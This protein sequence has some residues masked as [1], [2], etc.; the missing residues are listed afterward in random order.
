MSLAGAALAASAFCTF[1][2]NVTGIQALTNT[3]YYENEEDYVTRVRLYIGHSLRN[4]VRTIFSDDYKSILQRMNW[5][6]ICNW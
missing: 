4:V 6:G 1:S 5:S 3:F 2:V